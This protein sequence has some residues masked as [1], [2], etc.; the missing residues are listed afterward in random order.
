M[1]G[2]VSASRAIKEPAFKLLAWFGDFGKFCWRVA[3]T[4]LYRPFEFGEFLR[5][6]DTIGSKSL[7]LVVL[8]GGATGV[9][10]S[11]Q[12]RDSLTR[13][14]AKSLLPAVIIFSLVKETGPII[15]GLVVSGRVGAG[16][17]AE[18]GSMSVTEQ[19]DAMAVSGVEPHKF[20]AATRILACIM[21]LPLLTLAADAAGI[22][23]GWLAT[24]LAE[25]TS[26]KLF[27]NNGLNGVL[28]SD[29]LPSTFKTALF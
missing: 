7:P 6:L 14:G 21:A 19:I 18:L 1:L 12:T 8:A 22:V 27:L 25:P 29:F 5:Q 4:L 10:L 9:V 28:F 15:T 20:L 2:T 26:L 17:G 23:M 24:T 11:L 16:I 3:A 13:F